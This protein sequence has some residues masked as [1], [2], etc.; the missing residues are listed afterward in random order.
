MTPEIKSKPFFSTPER[1]HEL[2]V[3]ARSWIGTPFYP[4][5]RIKLVGVDCVNLAIGIYQAVGVIGEIKLPSYSV[6]AG[7][8]LTVSAVAECVMG[9]G[10]ALSL[11]LDAEIQT[12]DML[13]FKFGR[14]TH[15]VGVV[16]ENRRFVHSLRP[17]GVSEG[18]LSDPTFGANLTHIWRALEA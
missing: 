17:N 16:T 7:L 5:G 3:E 2:I 13:G 4:H 9:T 18:M 11:P 15:H 8:H 12:G 6:G 14:V 1:Q 10:R